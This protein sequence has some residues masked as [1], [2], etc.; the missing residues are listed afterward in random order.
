MGRSKTRRNVDLSNQ[1]P[2]NAA[3]ANSPQTVNRNI[4]AV[5]L[6]VE[7]KIVEDSMVENANL[8]HFQVYSSTFG[9]YSMQAVLLTLMYI[10]WDGLDALGTPLCHVNMRSCCLNSLPCAD[11][12]AKDAVRKRVL[13]HYRKEAAFNFGMQLIMAV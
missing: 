5:Q 3:G 4:L 7:R 1:T 11:K 10:I 6:A 8:V 9:R 2:I 13:V 12:Q